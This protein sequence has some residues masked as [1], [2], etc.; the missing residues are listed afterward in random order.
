ML[1][2]IRTTK[3]SPF[4]SWACWKADKR[5]WVTCT[6]W[7]R[8]ATFSEASYKT[9][10]SLRWSKSCWIATTKFSESWKIVSVLLKRMTDFLVFEIKIWWGKLE[11]SGSTNP[12]EKSLLKIH[13]QSKDSMF[14]TD[15][16]VSRKTACGWAQN[17]RTDQLHF[18]TT[19]Q[20]CR[21][22]VRLI[23]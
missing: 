15:R 16:H 12:S 5:H 11:A 4:R 22:I 20:A 7:G 2:S 13:F 1:T 10:Q 9:F 3:I 17:S 21:G 14:L 18:I 23:L 8:K 6:A 19:T